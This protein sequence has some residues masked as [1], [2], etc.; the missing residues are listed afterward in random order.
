MNRALIHILTIGLV[1]ASL[2]PPVSANTNKR[3]NILLILS[4]DHGF[5]D[6]GTYGNPLIQTPNIDKLASEGMQ[7]NSAFATEAI[8]AP[9][10]QSVYTGLYPLRH[11]G[12]RNHTEAFP[13]TL[14]LPHYFEPLGYQVYLAGKTHFGPKQAFP[15]IHLEKS[16]NTYS[17]SDSHISKYFGSM[18][19]L[20]NNT[21]QPF[22][23]VVATSLPHTI[24]GIN[25]GYPEPETYRPQDIP[26]PGY[27]VDTPQTR[28]ERAG[29]YELV[30]WLDREVGTMLNLLAN[31]AAKDNT[32]VIYTSDHGAGFAFEKWTNYDAGLRVPLIVKWPESVVA[33][34]Q[35]DVMVSLVDILPTLMEMAGAKPADKIDGESFLTVLKGESDQHHELIFATHTTLGI[36][37]ASDPM[38]IRSVR[39]ER[40][41]YIRNL[42]PQGTFTNNVTEKGQ[43]GWHSWV[44]KAKEDD[45]ALQQVTRYQH[46]PA[47][48]FYDLANDPYEL[49]NLAGDPEFQQQQA[50]L[51]EQ[52][53]LW[54]QQQG[55]LGLEAPVTPMNTSWWQTI[56]AAIFIFIQ[57]VMGLF[58]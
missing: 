1:I 50:Y 19:K 37:N 3:P 57:W 47:E 24:F 53:D 20:F 7:F 22:L 29:Y 34:S 38:P 31:S 14:S 51:S 5:E 13:D 6:S 27:L 32:I 46:R 58:Q 49:N 39:S 55:D 45:F 12:H 33:G 9:S 41:K 42:N 30:T 52:L 15:F 16:N 25:E 18:E 26:L 4:D 10:R 11:G 21:Q 40:F 44:E 48:E 23:L 43:G 36:R 17:D 8:C 28:Y 35:T 54:M 2:I 56:L